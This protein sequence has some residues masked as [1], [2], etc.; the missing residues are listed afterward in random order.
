M[1]E[2]RRAAFGDRPDA[3]VWADARSADPR[4]RW[5]AAVALGGQGWYAAAA[6]ALSG[7]LAHPDPVLAAMVGVTLAS[8]RRQLGAH[9]AART[10][11]GQALRRMAEENWRTVARHSVEF[12]EINSDDARVDALVGLAADA[13]GLGRVDEARRLHAAAGAVD[14]VSSRCAIRRDWVGAEIALAGGNPHAAIACAER[15]A[16]RA[17]ECPSIRHQAK[18]HLVLGVAM[19]TAGDAGGAEL[20]ERALDQALRHGLLPLVWPSALVLAG[21]PGRDPARF[22][23]FARGALQTVL[24]RADA[25]ARLLAEA[26]SWLPSDLLRSSDPPRT[27]GE[28]ILDGLST[29]SCQ[30]SAPGVR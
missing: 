2:L 6:T 7:L 23:P 14:H 18:S 13:V 4:R 3:D 26:S 22:T 15:A 5:L 16:V 28:T 10:L 21:L 1:D 9:A 20:L 24:R 17:S 25:R 8:H 27:G 11:D 30:G 29:G 19:A 12:P